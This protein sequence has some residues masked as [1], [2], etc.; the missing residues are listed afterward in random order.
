MSLCGLGPCDCRV[1]PVDDGLQ[2]EYWQQL[3]ATD[4]AASLSRSL[5]VIA[6]GGMHPDLRVTLWPL[7]LGVLPAGSSKSEQDTLRSQQR[8]LYTDLLQRLRSSQAKLEQEYA[9]QGGTETWFLTHKRILSDTFRTEPTSSFYNTECREAR[10]AILERI[11]V[12]Y[13]LTDPPTGYCQGMADLASA[14]LQVVWRDVP[15]DPLPTYD[16]VLSMPV[17]EANQ[18]VL[19]EVEVFSL[20][21]ALMESR[22][23]A[24]F[25]I[26]GEGMKAQYHEL[27]RL[28]LQVDPKLHAHLARCAGDHVYSFR[29]LLVLFRRE[30]THD[31]CCAFWEALWALERQLD[32]KLQLHC[33]IGV[34]YQNRKEIMRSRSSLEEMLRLFNDLPKT[35]DAKSLIAGTRLVLNL[36]RRKTRGS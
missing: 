9:Q 6:S 13:A 25:Q 27:N 28:L 24:N 22:M 18:S 17:G 20:F 36:E 3:F 26:T 30:L 14:F 29:A 10:L 11:L 4:P 7:L 33:I 23:R 2:V 34:L 35:A 5:P 21:Q 12:A 16:A 19:A 8:V 32:R 31:D 1:V 15:T